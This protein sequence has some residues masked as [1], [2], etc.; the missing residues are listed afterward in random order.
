M[1]LRQS[2]RNRQLAAALCGSALLALAGWGCNSSQ[3][4]D[5]DPNPTG[6][7]AANKAKYAKDSLIVRFR[8]TPTASNLRS[9]VAQ[10]NGT[11]ED[12]NNDGVYDRF[13]HI[14]SGQLA[15][16]KLG[17]GTDVDDAIEELRKDPEILYAERN[18]I[19]KAI[20]TPNDP[21]F[22]QLYGLDNTG[23]TGGTPDADIDAAEAWDSSV[24][25]SDVVI[26]VIDTGIDYNHEDLAANMWTNPGETPGNGVDDDGNGVIDDV[27]GFNAINGSGDPFD[28]HFHGTHCAGTIGAVG[29]NGIGVAGVNWETQ[30]MA[31]K[32]LDAGGSGTNE[33]AI[34]AIDY[35]IARRNEGVNLRVLSNSWG[36]GE[37]SQALLDAINEAGEAGMMFVAAAGNFASDNDGFA[38]YPA[39]YDAP[40]IVSVAATDHNDALADFSNFGA[41]TVDL[42]APGVGV[43]STFPGNSYEFLDGTS[44]ATPHVAGVAALAL[45][46]NGTLTI[47]ELK[48]ILLSSG[49]PLPALEGI[50]VSGNRLNAAAA[51]EQTG[52]PVPRFSLSVTPPSVVVTQEETATYGIDVA[53][54]AGFEGDVALTVTSD[55]AIEAT[56]SITD[57]VPAPGTGTLTV[58]TSLTT[59]TGLYTLTITGESGELVRSRTVRLRVRAEGDPLF[60]LTMSPES[61]TIF[62]SDGAQ[63]NIAVESFGL[64]GEVSLS[65]A[66]DPPFEGFV[67]LFPTEVPAPGSSALVAF[68]E[69]VAAPGDY[70]FTITGT[71]A[72]GE[73]VSDS[74]V[75]TVQASD[76]QPPFADF[77]WFQTDLTFEF[78]DFS[79]SPGCNSVPIVEWFWD[80]GDGETSFEQDPIHTY[81]A[82]GDY[83]V[84]LTVFDANGQS[85]SVTFTVSATPPPP[86]LSIFRIVRD[87]DRFE[88]R[89]NLRWSDLTGDLV[90]LFRNGQMVDI[91][92]NDGAVRDVFRQYETQYTWIMCEQN[93]GV[94]TNEVS[95]NFGPNLLDDEATITA[96]IDGNRV[97]ETV[98]IA[99]E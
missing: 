10:V 60:G 61:Q 51:L 12:K 37:F 72:D 82:P 14:A 58:E 20:A 85:D 64:E 44:M 21:S 18:Y 47:D 53:S 76:E 46:T 81:A 27:H 48:D 17:A 5:P 57:S 75:L 94:C 73:V 50:T 9:S 42:G 30:I 87:P 7:Q 19:V 56:L 45:A 40:S 22:P 74:S 25:S 63:F 90:E 77:F 31:L 95:V 55:P 80:F 92:D 41:T 70:T 38:F 88:F 28:D 98:D 84:T 49:D 91:P 65:F 99:T 52:P 1:R 83:D 35:A 11:I 8:N 26:A 23:Q 15:V 54:L 67:D 96:V 16:V 13:S 93:G 4:P 36:G 86:P 3:D 97:V 79:F 33:D 68:A 29:N 32:F 34:S 6:G 78:L 69:C 24:G 2:S 43:L 66:S 89:V 71:S 39:S 62:D 59:V